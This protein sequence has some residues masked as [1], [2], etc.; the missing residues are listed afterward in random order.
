MKHIV[1]A[2]TVR[3]RR[4][5]PLSEQS[6]G[7]TLNPLAFLISRQISLA[8][9]GQDILRAPVFSR[10]ADGTGTMADLTAI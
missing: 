9:D 3:H 8:A 2:S 6:Q 10:A 5:I 1:S 4:L 7:K